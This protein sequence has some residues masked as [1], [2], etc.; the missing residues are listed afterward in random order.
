MLTAAVRHVRTRR[1]RH[2]VLGAGAAA[3]ILLAAA[4]ALA[5]TAGDLAGNAIARVNGKAVTSHDLALALRRLADDGRVSPPPTGRQE[6]LGFL[7]DQELLIQRGVEIGLLE[8]DRTVRKVIAMAMIDAVVAGV[9]KKEPTEEELR[10]FYASHQPVFTA[11]ARVHVQHIAFGGDGDLARALAQAERAST[12]IAQGVSFAETRE[13]YGDKDSAPV[14]DAPVPFH[15]LHRHFGPGL[16]NAALAMPVGAIS[17]PLPSPWGYHLLRVVESQ[18][19]HVQPYEAVRQAVKAEYF[20]RRRD[21]A[22]QHY[23][24]RLREEATIVLSPKAPVGKQEKGGTR[25]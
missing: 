1:A 16:T 23:L 2:L 9:L 24:D 20:R 12:A 17:R 25:G 3:G 13:R 15:V 6:A 21:E 11:P 5:P 22:L 14:P 4:G 18:P 8:S 19:E 7:I 10:A